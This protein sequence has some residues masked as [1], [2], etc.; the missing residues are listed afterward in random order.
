MTEEKQLRVHGNPNPTGSKWLN[1][2]RQ[3]AARNT[4]EHL[5]RQKEDREFEEA[6]A[7][8]ITTQEIISKGKEDLDMPEAENANS[9][10]TLESSQ[11]ESVDSEEVKN[12]KKE[13]QKERAAKTRL[14]NK[15]AAQT[16]PSGEKPSEPD[17]VNTTE[18]EAK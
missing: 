16:D 1:E 6:K 12:L 9:Q 8:G 15:L 7:R 2:V 11:S 17:E 14:E 4:I 13:L 10:P 5:R 3:D 18:E